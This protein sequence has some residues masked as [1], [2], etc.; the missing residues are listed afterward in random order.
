MKNYLLNIYLKLFFHGI[1]EKLVAAMTRKEKTMDSTKKQRS[2]RNVHQ[3]ANY[4]YSIKDFD[5]VETNQRPHVDL[6]ILAN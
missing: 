4:E 1:E 2:Q 6:A 3:Q 5:P